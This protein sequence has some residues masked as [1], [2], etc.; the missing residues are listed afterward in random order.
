MGYKMGFILSLIF[1][2]QLFVIAGDMFSLQVI[3]T[4]LDAV[5]V[6]AGQAI[7]KYGEITDSIILLVENQAHASIEGLTSEPPSFGMLYEYRIYTEYQ[8]YF[9]SSEPMEVSIVRSVVIGYQS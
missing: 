2:A 9:I 6:T 7:S 8:P 5:S 1:I 3:Y 4:N